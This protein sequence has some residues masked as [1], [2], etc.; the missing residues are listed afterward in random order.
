MRVV[1][2]IARWFD[3]AEFKHCFGCAGGSIR[4]FR[5][6]L[7]PYTAIE[8]IQAQHKSQAV[9]MADRYR[10]VRGKIAPIP[11]SGARP[12]RHTH[13]SAIPRLVDGCK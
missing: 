5:D 2:A 6:A 7:T 3:A 9:R 1:D 8:E 12:I 13:R 10:R 4:L 11:T